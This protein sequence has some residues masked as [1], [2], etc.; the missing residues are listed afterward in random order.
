[1]RIHPLLDWTEVDIWRYIRQENIPFVS[2]YLD[3]GEGVRYRSL[4]CAPCTSPVESTAKTVD[5]IID[6]LSSGRFSRI[7]E[8]AG[9]GQ[10]KEDGGG[11]EELRRNGYM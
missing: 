5:D 8:R 4:G 2:L 1:M 11:L 10:D 6:E 7:A 9:R 3:Q